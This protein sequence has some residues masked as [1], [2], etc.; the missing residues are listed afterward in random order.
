MP[1]T[2][3][4]LLETVRIENGEI[5]NLPY[6]QARFDKSRH[7]FYGNTTTVDLASHLKAPPDGLY[8][9]RILY[10]ESIR[11]IEYLP[12][13]PKTIRSLKIVPSDIDYRYKY[14]D[15]SALDALLQ[16]HPQAD[17]VIIE[18]NGLLCDTTIANIA[19]FN[20]KQWVTPKEPLLEGTM[21]AF[22][23]DK[24]LLRTEKITRE[25]LTAYTHVA[26]MNA[27]IG[28]KILNHMNIQSQAGR[29]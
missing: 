27:M 12:Y 14:A 25:S 10:A 5:F 29:T 17:E 24:G 23:L 13:V 6:H 8:R 26:L 3:P 1:A 2:T 21:R 7:A 16:A 19:F 9:C 22:F 20:G 4:L 18:K 15:R 28:F 11:H